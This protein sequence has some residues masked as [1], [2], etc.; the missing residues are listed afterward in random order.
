MRLQRIDSTISSVSG[1]WQKAIDFCELSLYLRNL[2]NFPEQIWKT[3]KELLERRKVLR[4]DPN[5]SQIER[6]LHE[7]NI[8]LAALLSEDGTR[9]SSRREMEIITERF[10][11]NLFLSS[12]PVSS[13]II[14][15]GEA[16][17]RILPSEKERIPDQW[18]TSRAVL[19]HKKGVQLLGPHPDRVEGHRGLPGIPPPLVLTLVDYE[20]ALDGVE[21]NT[22]LLAL[23]VQGVDASDA[24]RPRGRTQTRWTD[25]FAMTDGPAESSAGY[26]PRISSTSLTKLENIM[27]DNGEGTKRAEE[28]LG[29]ARPV[30]TGHLSI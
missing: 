9:T 28:I 17:P 22:V 6:D 19:I 2:R 26:G 29:P 1:V 4:L 24:K 7:C 15:T 18:K 8:P 10:Y 5:A 14:P 16:P 3:T 21:T 27:D 20:K 30:K 12:T 25:V 13:P 11:S 23:V